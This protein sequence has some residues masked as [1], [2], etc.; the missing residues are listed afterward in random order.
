[1]LTKY[2]PV[3]FSQRPHLPKQKNLAS[4]SA[5]FKA[6]KQ[7]TRFFHMACFHM[8]TIPFLTRST[9]IKNT[10]PGQNLL[11]GNPCMPLYTQIKMPCQTLFLRQILDF[12]GAPGKHFSV[13]FR[14]DLGP[15]KGGFPQAAELPATLIHK[16]L[17]FNSFNKKFGGIPTPFWIRPFL[18]KPTKSL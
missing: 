3:K 18:I 14:P 4:V 5:L 11:L 15:Q 2:L 12:F 16:Y 7:V 1:M 10:I 17:K 6:L 13:I 8:G 9:H